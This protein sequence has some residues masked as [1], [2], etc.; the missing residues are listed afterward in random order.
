MPLLKRALDI[1]SQARIGVY[2]CLYIALAEREGYEL[3]TADHGLIRGLK[4]TFHFIPSLD[5]L[6]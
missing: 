1:A 3:V 4:P 6:P 5:S 2:D